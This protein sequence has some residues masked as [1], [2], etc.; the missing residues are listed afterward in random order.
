[1]AKKETCFVCLIKSPM[2]R[3]FGHPDGSFIWIAPKGWG[4]FEISSCEREVPLC[5]TCQKKHLED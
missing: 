1:M 3:D 5:P 4:Y 2:R